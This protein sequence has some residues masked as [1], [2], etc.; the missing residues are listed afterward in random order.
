M[1]PMNACSDCG[2]VYPIG[3]YHSCHDS[4][5]EARREQRQGMIAGMHREMTPLPVSVP[6][7]TVAIF[8]E[9]G[10][11]LK[12]VREA[13]GIRT[14]TPPRDYRA[15]MVRHSDDG[16]PTWTAS[17]EDRAAVWD[18]YKAAMRDEK[19]ARHNPP[20][21]ANPDEGHRLARAFALNHSDDYA[22]RLSPARRA[23]LD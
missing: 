6:E 9:L 4:A 20:G 11:M 2:V 10:R 12:D 8:E 23:G 5:L 7:S 22:D 21:H 15:V 13:T 19:R 18:C 16:R 17:R 14:W 1:A 3:G